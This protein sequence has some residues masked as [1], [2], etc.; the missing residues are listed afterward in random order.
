MTSHISLPS[1]SLGSCNL[2]PDLTSVLQSI[3][4][5]KRIIVISGAG[6][7]TGA[8]I[9]DFRSHS[10]LFKVDPNANAIGATKITGRKIKGSRHVKDLFHV[11]ALSDPALLPHHHGLM[12]RLAELADRA[13]PTAFHRWLKDIDDSGRLVRCYTQNIDGLE[14]KAGLGVGVPLGPPP[15]KRRKIA[16]S[17]VHSSTT[18]V[19]TPRPMSTTIPETPPP[20]SNLLPETDP[21]PFFPPTP[22]SSQPTASTSTSPP[23][24]IPLHGTLSDLTC[25]RCSS[26]FPLGPHLPLP[27]HHLPCPSCTLSASLRAALAERSRPIGNLRAGVVLY[28]EH[29][30]HGES[31]GAAVERDLRAKPAV[32]LVLVV[33]TSLSVPGVK[34]MV[35]EFAR[36]V[37][38]SRSNGASGTR[39]AEVKCV[40]VNREWLGKSWEGV[41]DTFLKGDAEDFVRLVD[42]V[43]LMKNKE[44][45]IQTT[46]KKRRVPPTPESLAK[47]H[48]NP[49]TRL[50]KSKTPRK[51]DIKTADSDSSTAF[52]TPPKKIFA[53]TGPGC[54]VGG[55]G[56]W[57]PTPRDTP[58][59]PSSST[60]DLSITEE[61]KKDR[62]REECIG[63]TSRDRSGS[64]TP[65]S[66]QEDVNP[67]LDLAKRIL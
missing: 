12:T 27:P 49:D 20:M 1:P 54:D 14:S 32:D 63:K 44:G 40:C 55:G 39:T 23:R 43:R 60:M 51:H 13:D 10:G 52:R 46:P 66:D 31:I 48:K 59:S 5:A 22:P 53:S 7:S 36:S 15:R 6:I 2:D 67:F 30:P 28:G 9:P 29:H 21:D 24:V 64:L 18:L 35:T 42:E 16:T 3:N 47:R 11:R 34:R 19:E 41:F 38:S 8:Q 57:L 45:K 65:L 33:G 62:A 26:H 17:T 37:R 56:G 58:P 25:P 4:A 50:S 61:I